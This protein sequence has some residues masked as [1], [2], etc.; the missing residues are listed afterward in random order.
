MF[1]SRGR[2]NRKRKFYIAGICAC[3]FLYLFLFSRYQTFEYQEVI[4]NSNPKDVWEFVSDFRKMKELNPTILDFKIVA[5]H[6]N[7]E[8]WQYTVEYTETLSHWPHWENKAVGNY[9]AKKVIR[10]RKYVYVIDS[11]HKTCFFALYCGE[12]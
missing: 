11:T 9:H 1:T 4:K 10:D 12:F 6:G 2:Y 5:D 8:D 7:L 3:I